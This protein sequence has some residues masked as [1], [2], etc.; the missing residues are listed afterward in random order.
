M[1]TTYIMTPDNLRYW[2]ITPTRLGRL[3]TPLEPSAAEALRV[4]GVPIILD[5]FAELPD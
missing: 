2:L 3:W 4:A 5:A 1:P